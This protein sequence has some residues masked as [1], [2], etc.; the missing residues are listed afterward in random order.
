[1]VV[2][3][4]GPGNNMTSSNFLTEKEIA[5]VESSIAEVEKRTCAELVPVI[6]NVSGRYERAEG[7][8]AF[9]FSLIVFVSVWCMFQGI[10]PAKGGW[11][12]DS[13][14]L[15]LPVM[16]VVLVLSYIVGAILASR[17][18]VL[19]LFLITKKE[20][21]EEVERRAHE[22]FQRFKTRNTINGTGVLIYISL[23][24]HMVHVVGDDA[25]NAKLSHDD[26]ESFCN[27]ILEGLKEGKP[28]QGLKNGILHCGE[29]LAKYFPVQAGDENELPN[30]IN[31][32]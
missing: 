32:I 3:Q 24:E 19:R 13:L 26:W 15:N 11:N 7:L 14:T 31:F 30:K 12:L 23:Y 28:E 21:C 4:Q 27:I 25:I 2:V 9:A 29:L 16:L 6:A 17:L 22:S 18:P 20:M 8:F 10:S 5:S 1:M